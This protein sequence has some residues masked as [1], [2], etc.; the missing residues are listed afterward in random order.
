M[1]VLVALRAVDPLLQKLDARAASSRTR[2]FAVSSASAA[3]RCSRAASLRSLS[4]RASAARAGATAS[5]ASRS[6][7]PL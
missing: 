5:F 7:V 1:I 2:A 3:N 6:G 4:A